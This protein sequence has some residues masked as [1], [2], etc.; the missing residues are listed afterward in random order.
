MPVQSTY[1]ENIA[2]GY[3]GQVANETNF[4]VDTKK[5]ETAAGIDFGRAVSR[6]TD[7]K[8]CVLGGATFIGVTV[9]D[10]TL[11]DSA[12]DKYPQYHLAGVLRKGDI[13]LKPSEG[14]TDGAQVY[15][16]T[17][18]GRFGVSG[19]GKTAI[20]GAYWQTTADADTLAVARF[21]SPQT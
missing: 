16:D 2:K 18:T 20:V 1:S 12:N 4:D 9:R 5:V 15:Y 10:I 6:G 21:N 13:W 7:D 19:G 8:G 17:T 11:Q 14:V 3:E